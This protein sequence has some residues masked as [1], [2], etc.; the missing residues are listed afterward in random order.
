MQEEAEVTRL[1]H[2]AKCR[3]IISAAKARPDA[4]V[5]VPK[6]M[7]WLAL[8]DLYYLIVYILNRKDFQHDWLHNRCVEVQAHPD[9]YLDLWARDHRKSTTI[10]FAKTIQD[11]LRNPEETVGIFSHTKTAASGFLVQI[12]TEFENN[13]ALYKLFPDILY[14]RPEREAPTWTQ[15][16]IT[17]KRT[18]NPKEA[19]VEAWGL[20]KGQPIGRHYTLMIYDDVITDEE[21]TSPEMIQKAT[22]AWAQSTNLVSSGRCRCR[23]IGTRYHLYDT[24]SEIIKREVAIPRI[25]PATDNGKA[26]G[27]PVFLTQEALDE[28]KKQG[29]YIF[30]CQQL[31]NPIAEEDQTFRHEWKRFWHPVQDGWN[32]M[33]VYFVIDPAGTKKRKNNDYMTMWAIG[34]NSDENYY[35]I[36]IVRDKL[37]LKERTDLLFD[38]HAKYRPLNVG[39][40]RYSMQTDIE[41]IQEEMV[42]R[43][44]R[45]E[46]VELAGNQTSKNDRIRDSLQPLFEL[47]RFY[48]PFSCP[49]VDTQGKSS[50]L[51]RVFFEQEYDAFPVLL[52]DDMLDSL[53][54]I[55]DP[56]LN[57]RFPKLQAKQNLRK[58]RRRSGMA[59]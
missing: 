55:R 59:A 30:S 43:N 41:H 17:L 32:G 19:T 40:E 8:N 50:D 49:Y 29:S 20:I 38:W 22:D 45:F 13:K 1:E 5:Q 56:K 25:H 35:A 3:E 6:A 53:S 9:G 47:G 11:I 4:A 16:A 51:T 46:I 52:H 57:A 2:E 33:N 23:Y 14:E 26:D 7:R 24:W 21:C 54:R 48:L 39:Y 12:K 31:L 18:T 36:D 28:K 10:T 37:T 34:L 44:Y 27:N 58:V 15:D 42:R